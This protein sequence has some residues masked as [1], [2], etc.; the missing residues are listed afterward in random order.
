MIWDILGVIAGFAAVMLLLS[1]IVTSV[2][3]LLKHALAF[4][5]RNAVAAIAEILADLKRPADIKGAPP[6]ATMAQFREMASSYVAGTRWLTATTPRARL[7]ERVA[8][9][10]DEPPADAI[11]EAMEES[12]EKDAETVARRYA[13]ASPE[14]QE[15]Y[16]SGVRATTFLCSILVAFAFQVSTPRLFSRLAQDPELAA[17]QGESVLAAAGPVLR[18]LP[19]YDDVSAEAL[20]RLAATADEEVRGRLEEASGSG[21]D[22]EFLL[23]E[24]R[25]VLED[26][27]PAK[28]DKALRDYE[29]LLGELRL[30]A[31]ESAGTRARD[32]ARGLSGLGI[33]IWQDGSV[34]YLGPGGLGNLIGVLI[35]A[36]FLMLG[37]PFWYWVLQNAIGLRKTLGPGS[38]APAESMPETAPAPPAK[39]PKTGS[40]GKAEDE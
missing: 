5:Q 31:V 25:R 33:G 28:R 23:D 13:E 37:A 29:K 2:V 32:A 10:G 16:R 14:L 4:K 38:A 3:Q 12:G 36:A 1:V 27:S 35:T 8:G 20:D 34:F 40:K 30:E 39:K 11:R 21:E 15:R 22:C 7:V 26:V 19:R 6:P 18:D 17:R 9:G 24:L